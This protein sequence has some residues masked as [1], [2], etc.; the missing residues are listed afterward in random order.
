MWAQEW[1][2]IYSI[3]QP[4]NLPIEDYNDALSRKF[5]G[6]VTQMFR[7]AVEFYTSIGLFNM[8][9]QFWERSILTKQKNIEMICH[10]SAWDFFEH[11]DFR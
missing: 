2:N 11:D 5:N 7:A 3:V 4:Y 8:T 6:D 1:Q 10:A 9:E